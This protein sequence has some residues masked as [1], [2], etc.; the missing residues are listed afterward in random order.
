MDGESVSGR[1]AL[2]MKRVRA[3][4]PRASGSWT[5]PSVEGALNAYPCSKSRN[6]PVPPPQPPNHADSFH[7][8]A[9]RTSPPPRGKNPAGPAPAPS[10]GLAR[11]G[12]GRVRT[13][14]ARVPVRPAS[15]PR[16]GSARV[17]VL[18]PRTGSARV[19]VLS[20]SKTGRR[21]EGATSLPD[22]RQGRERLSE[23]QPSFFGGREA[24]AW[25]G[26][27]THWQGCEDGGYLA[28]GRW[29]KGAQGCSEQRS[30]L[31]VC[32]IS[33]DL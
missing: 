13:H 9:A 11:P 24:T 30:F 10:A 29:E 33:H 21:I 27:L 16:T 32:L 22:R 18:C 17:P 1:D 4:R 2:R 6:A 20:D 26:G 12:A 8:A 7:I 3:L 28:K 31:V 5:N 14:P 15:G 23:P 25:R 19:P